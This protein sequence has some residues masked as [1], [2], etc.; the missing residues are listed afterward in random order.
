VNCG[1]LSGLE[2]LVT[3]A[4]VVF[5]VVSPSSIRDDHVTK[6]RE[7]AAVRTVRCYVV[8]E[9]LS[10]EVTVFS[11]SAHGEDWKVT[12]L[13][14]GQT[15]ELAALGLEIPVAALYSAVTLNG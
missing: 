3:E 4:V 10:A 13:I 2:R 12:V 5:E 6:L 8:L 14:A 11:R 9:D 15:L 7:Y 1:P